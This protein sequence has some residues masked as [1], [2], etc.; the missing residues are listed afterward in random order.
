MVKYLVL[1]PLYAVAIKEFKYS[2]SSCV[3]TLCYFRNNYP[4]S[5]S[6]LV[7][8]WAV[9]NIINGVD[10]IQWGINLQYIITYWWF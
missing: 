3:I 9:N 6:N 2:E 4:S 8:Y 10:L 5:I 7:L 1:N